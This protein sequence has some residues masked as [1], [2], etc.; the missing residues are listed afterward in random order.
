M[1]TAITEGKVSFVHHEKDYISIEYTANGRKK[2]INGKVDEATQ[3]KWKE[4]KLIK[5]PHHFHEGDEVSFTIVRSDRGDKMVADRIVYRFNNALGNLINRAGTENKFVGYLKLVDDQYFV[6]ETGSYLFFPLV[7]LPW[8]S[9][10]S[11]KAL[12]EPVFFRLENTDNPE[13]VSATL[14]KHR[15]I[16]EFLA[17]KKY[18]AE[19][20]VIDAVIYKVSRHSIHVNVIGEKIQAKIPIDAKAEENAGIRQLKA[21]DRLKLVISYLSDA[22][23][24]VTPI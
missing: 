9:R 18:Y 23:I 16:P 22:K 8:E 13:K 15:F 20:T 2:T 12:N 11:D 7:L 14:L 3:L 1:T 19:K 6:K 10:P 5:K 24:I 21:G 4:E 17:A